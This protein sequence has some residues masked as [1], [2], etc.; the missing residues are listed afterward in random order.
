VDAQKLGVE[1][2]VQLTLTVEGDSLA[3]EVSVPSLRNLRVVGGPFQSTQVSFVNGAVSQQLVYTWVLQPAAVGKAEVG[4][5]TV[6]LSGG[7]KTTEPIALEVVPGSIRPA[8]RRRAD[9]FDPFGGED[10]FEAFFGRRN[11]NRPPPKV[12]VKAVPSR[13]RLYI[14]ES[15]LLSYFVY[16]Q[17]EITDLRFAD[18]PSYPGFWSEDLPQPKGGPRGEPATLEGERFER[19]A[20][21]RKL[22]FPTRAGKLEVPAATFLIGVPRQ[23]FFDVGS[24]GLPRSSQAVAIDVDPIPEEPGFSG[25]VG[26][27]RATASLDKPSVAL[28]EAATLRFR[29]EGSGNLKWIDKG[30]TLELPGAKVYPPSTTSDLETRPE[31]IGGSKTWE[32]AIVPETA[33]RLEVPPLSFAYFDPAAGRVVRTESAAL[34]LA[35]Q[36]GGATAALPAASALP[37][38]SARGVLPLRAELD[39]PSA[40]LPS[41]SARVVALAFAA[42]GLLHL[43]LLVGPGVAD[44]LRAARGRP[45]PRAQSRAA[46]ADIE[47]VRR[48]RL[49]KEAAAAALEK[50]LHD[51]FGPL[52]DGSAP[53]TGERERA[54]RAVL[55][56][57]QFLRYAPQLGDYS[58]KIRDV[59]DRA[60]ALVR[61]WA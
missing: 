55:D 23:G 56:E 10:P 49:G 30:P 8:R 13:S 52:E 11:A 60:A 17:T 54:A 59:A 50:A 47:R 36:G 24:A 12:L 31:G 4:A 35:V 20:I 34:P 45:A 44:R 57:V 48:D 28:G 22:L 5:F 40:V 51:V 53:A 21:L 58:D 1:D 14:G 9:P 25:A 6:K 2:Q 39:P 29:V 15:L 42:A 33:G 26:R 3:Q 27:F 61:R 37:L 19:F 18:A 43:A 32:F 41:P 7:D 16:T 46:L 38:A